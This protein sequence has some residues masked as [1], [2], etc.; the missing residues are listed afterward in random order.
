[1]TSYVRMMDGGSLQSHVS[2]HGG[3]DIYVSRIYFMN[4]N[5]VGN[6]IRLSFSKLNSLPFWRVSDFFAPRIIQLWI[7]DSSAI[8][9]RKWSPKAAMHLVRLGRF[10][11]SRKKSI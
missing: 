9:I 7:M 6:L 10:G 1:M 8:L 4:E 3:C 11:C 5:G 2:Q